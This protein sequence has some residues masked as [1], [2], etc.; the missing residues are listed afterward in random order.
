M[1]MPLD[2]EQPDE[3]LVDE[4]EGDEVDDGDD[5]SDE[6]IP[7]DESESPLEETHAPFAKEGH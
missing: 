1:T 7:D 5:D 6:D 3:D 2:I 4:V